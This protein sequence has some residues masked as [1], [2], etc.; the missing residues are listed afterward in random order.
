MTSIPTKTNEYDQLAFQYVGQL[1]F[2]LV[3]AYASFSLMNS[4]FT[5]WYS[6]ILSTLAG[7]VYTFGK[8]A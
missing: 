4:D 2:P 3:V 7:F 6:F 8:T 5:S 1:A